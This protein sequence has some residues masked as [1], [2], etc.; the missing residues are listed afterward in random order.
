[1]KLINPGYASSDIAV[2]GDPIENAIE[3][4]RDD[5]T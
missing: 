5:I 2:F 4:A 1:M 3:Q